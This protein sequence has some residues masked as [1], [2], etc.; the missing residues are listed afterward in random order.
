MQMLP[1]PADEFSVALATGDTA[2]SRFAAGGEWRRSVDASPLEVAL[3]RK[4]LILS[5][6]FTIAVLVYLGLGLATPRYTAEA[7]VRIDLPQ[8]RYSGD[9]ASVIPESQITA[10]GVHTEMAALGSPRLA[11][12]AAVAMGLDKRRDYQ[13]CPKESLLAMVK[14]MFST[15]PLPPCTE[16][17]TEAGRVL[18]DRIV[19]GNDKLSYIIQVK[20]SDPNPDEAARIANGFATAYVNYQRDTKIALA[21]EADSWLGG[22]LATVQAA[23]EKAD[24][25]VESYRQEHNLVDLH[26]ETPGVTDTA[27]SRHFSELNQQLEAVQA[28]ITEKQSTLAQMGAAGTGLDSV[29]VQSLLERHDELAST[30]ANLRATLGE[31]HPSVQAAA[32]ALHRNEAQTNA[33]IGRTVA[34]QNGQLAALI[35]RRDTIAA[36][37]ATA[38][39]H[40]SDESQARVK[41]EELQ[42]EAATERTLYE[43][44]FVRLKQVDAERRLEVANAAI[45]VEA[46]APDHPVFPRKIMMTAGAFLAALGAGVG[47][48][49]IYELAS[50]RFQGADQVEGEIGLPVLGLFLRRNR[51]PHDMVVD[52]P[53]SL[54]TEAVHAALTQIL[55]TP[56]GEPPRQGRTIMVTS[57]LPHEGKSSFSVSLGRA[58]AIAGHSVILLDCDLRRPAVARLLW[59]AGMPVRRDRVAVPTGPDGAGLLDTV[60]TDSKTPLRYLT[61]SSFFGKPRG[62]STWAPFV[63][64]WRQARAEYDIVLIDTPPV[65][66]TSEATELGSFAD[67]V[68]MM[69]A[70]Q[71][72]PREA[73]NESV[74]VLRRAGIAV[75]G[76]ILSKVDL[77]RQTERGNLYFKA[78]A[79]YAQRL[80]QDEGG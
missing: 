58:A 56:P 24:H 11:E 64:L 19:I 20:A 65:L 7:D 59:S 63:E 16:S 77:R 80:T 45:V 8:L 73:A 30:L 35:A 39:S 32:S 51:A 18:L 34:A 52:E 22:Q 44:L 3:R 68:V 47:G 10:E 29:V 6:A 43:S 71:E 42:R 31:N 66:A 33:E 26:T 4:W 74:R 36:Q 57:S 13:I 67:D 53:L 37:V 40:M 14:A 78:H 70:L 28:S 76:T 27:A 5:L 50:G 2:E 12:K 75:R 17:A 25:A 60:M 15:G 49:F 23:M 9:S 55:R 38:S 72:T 1:P 69:V 62:L 41:L 79:A 61:L 21:Q 46:T 54:E 48:S